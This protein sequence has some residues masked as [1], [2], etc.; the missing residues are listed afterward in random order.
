MFD[1]TISSYPTVSTYHKF[2]L[3]LSY[4]LRPMRLNRF[5]AGPAAALHKMLARRRRRGR[6]RVYKKQY[7]PLAAA[8]QGY[9]GLRLVKISGEEPRN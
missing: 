4:L 7:R 3:G 8:P 1:K 6:A 9:G 5:V 2:G